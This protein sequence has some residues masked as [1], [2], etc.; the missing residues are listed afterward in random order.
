MEHQGLCEL[1]SIANGLTFRKITLLEFGGFKTRIMEPESSPTFPVHPAYTN[2]TLPGNIMRNHTSN[3]TYPVG[4]SDKAT[5][6]LF[7]NL[8]NDPEPSLRVAVGSDSN[9]GIKQKLKNV[10]ADI[11]KHESW[12]DSLSYQTP[13]VPQVTH[14]AT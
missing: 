4:D 6:M 2:P 8:A 12:S 7:H 14:L 10:E 13:D 3:G 11:T 5:T 9:S 1:G